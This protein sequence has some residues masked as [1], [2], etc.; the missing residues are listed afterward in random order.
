MLFRSIH[1]IVWGF[2]YTERKI[3]A[4]IPKAKDILKSIDRELEATLPQEVLDII[5]AVGGHDGVRSIL[6]QVIEHCGVQEVPEVVALRNALA[7]APKPISRG[8]MVDYQLDAA[9]ALAE[10]GHTDEG[11]AMLETTLAVLTKKKED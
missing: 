10:A 8:R 7:S 4:I 6:D 2:Y 3:V 9:L 11:Y 5:Q 1:E